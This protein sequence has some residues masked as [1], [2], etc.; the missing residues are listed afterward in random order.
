MPPPGYTG[1]VP[2]SPAPVKMAAASMPPLGYVGP[3]AR[4]RVSSGAVINTVPV[5]KPVIASVGDQTLINTERMSFNQADNVATAVGHVE[6]IYD[7]YVLHADKVV[8]NQKTNVMRAEG[9]VSMLAPSGEVQFAD[10]EEITGDM[11]EAFAANLGVL[12][13]DNSRMAAQ[14]AQRYQGRYLVAENDVYTA[15]NVCKENPDHEPLWQLSAE[16]VV[17]DNVE[18]NIYYHNA[19]LDFAGMP[20]LY[21]PYFSSPDPEVTR[22]Q[23][24]MTPSPGSTPDAGYFVRVPYYFDIAP[25]Q[26]AIFAPTFS[27]SDIAQLG[28]EYRRRF[29][30]GSLQLDGTVAYADLLSEDTGLSKGKRMRGNLFGSFLYNI[31][32]EWR[33]GANANYVSDKSYL[34]RY[35]MGSATDVGDHAFLE[36]FKGRNYFS[37]DA[38]YFQDLRPGP[39]PVQPM[40]LPQVGYSALGEPG[41]TL[42]GRWSFDA[43]A[44]SILRDNSAAAVSQQGPETRR[45][46]ANVGWERQFISDTGLVA[47]LSGLVRGDG[48][49][50]DEVQNPAV[51]AS[52]FNNVLLG[53]QFE[54]G[55][56]IARYPMARRGEEYQQILEPIAMITAAPTVKLDPRQPIEDSLNVQFDITNL[57]AP[58]RFTGTDLIEGGSRVVYGLR[59]ALTTDSGARLDMFGGESYSFTRDGTFPKASGLGGHASDY[60]GLVDFSPGEWLNVDYGF[61]FKQSDWSPQTQDV[62]LDFGAPIFRPSLRYLLA[63]Q[64]TTDGTLGT[65][66]EGIV[67][68][69]S[70]IFKYWTFSATHTQ[71]FQPAPGPRATA[72]MISYQD[73]CFIFGVE[74]LQDDTNRLDVRSGTSVMFHLFLKNIGGV[75]TD[76]F[77]GATFPAQFRQTN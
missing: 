16:R 36:Q 6:I 11:K 57:F 51:P 70:T 1:P 61:R 75:H 77:T 59:H 67:G 33:A 17:H 2:R 31:D 14:S 27:S 20:V 47:T 69:S 40:V 28:G 52:H 71:G 24:F 44:L 55:N 15:C 56:L 50:A 76:S 48:Y 5:A 34:Q 32:N 45:L 25:D 9:H 62:H 54:Q 65:I 35:N 19:T 53:R 60:V 63:H 3:V 12:F 7:G 4:H 49:W 37:T 66:E 41:Q 72:G 39:Q 73:E 22:R 21:T 68:F 26:D 74:V 23:G 43:S 29:A 30:R 18:H 58:N 10:E 13:T 46:S 38:Y 42:G 8:Y 64:T